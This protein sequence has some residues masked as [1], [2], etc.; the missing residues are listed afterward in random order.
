MTKE[1]DYKSL[2]ESADAVITFISKRMYKLEEE[3]KELE[4]KL[5]LAEVQLNSYFLGEESTNERIKDLKNENIF[6]RTELNL[7][8]KPDFGESF[9]HFGDKVT[10]MGEKP[11]YWKQLKICFEK[12]QR[13]VTRPNIGLGVA[14]L[15][16][17]LMHRREEAENKLIEIKLVLNS[18]VGGRLK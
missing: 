7:L 16:E 14:S 9:P 2:Y 12:I 4:K 8:Y 11:E 13:I 15:E 6:L 5:E 1:K 3:K 17:F 18:F 10:I